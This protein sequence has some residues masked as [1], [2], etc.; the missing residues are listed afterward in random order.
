MNLNI[1]YN[2]LKEYLATKKSATEFAKEISLGG[3]SVDHIIEQKSNFEK[4]VV[5]EILELKKHP[6]ADKLSLCRVNI[7]EEI[8]DIVCGAPNIKA[9]QKVPA[10]L[11]G[12]RVGEMKINKTKI[13]GAESSG[14]LC[15]QKELGL[16][17]D[18]AGI[19]ILPDYVKTGL[20]LEKVMPIAD[21][22][23]DIEI[24]SNRPDTM[25]V[26]GI[27]R[28]AAAIFG[29]KLKYAEPKPNLKIK[30]EIKLSVAVKELK[31]CPRYQAIVMNNAKVG[32]SPLWMQQRLLAAGLRPIN[33]LADITNYV[34]LEFGQ[35]MHVFDYDKLKGAEI[36]VRL[37]KKGEHILALDGK[38]YELTKNNLVIADAQNPVA[39]AGVMGGELSAAKTETKTIVFEAA[40]FD[41]I[42][43]RQTSRLLN[44]HSESSDLFE[45]GLSAEGTTPA[46][47]RA[48]ELAM[49]LAGAEPAS[50]VLDQ[51]KTAYKTKLISL[52]KEN[53]RRILGVKIPQEKIKEIL[54]R[55]GFEAVGLGKIKVKV[56]YWRARDVSEEHDLI[57]EIARVYGYHNLPAK[58][59]TGEIPVGHA[60]GLEFAWEDSVKDILAG[61]GFSE[62]Y[63]YS[64][65]SEKLIANCGLKIEN[66]IK[67]ANPLSA[68]FEYLRTALA[69]GILQAVSENAG[70]YKTIAIFELSKVYLAKENNLPAE[71][72]HLGIGVKGDS[73]ERVFA[74][75]KGALVSLMEKIHINDYSLAIMNEGAT[76][77]QKGKTV[78]IKLK[79][80]TIGYL[81]I[82]NQE[83]LRSFGIKGQAGLIELD[84]EKLVKEAKTSP[85]FEPIPVYPGIDLDLSMEID[86]NATYQAVVKTA[87]AVNGLIRAVAFLSV[88][89]GEKIPAGKKA[90]AIRVT[91]RDDS[92]TLTLAEAQ[93]IHQQVVG[94]LKRVYNVSVR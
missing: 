48:V 65:I 73:G 58:L 41:P 82:I 22:I 15:S 29:E 78:E 84:F 32:A 27:A 94:E 50:A 12:G 80:E 26:I 68:D 85:A 70:V 16:G 71:I 24:T 9:G 23:L 6:D 38:T 3:P 83:V 77:W 81:G 37:A 20:P 10:V 89:E 67:I 8:L 59:M 86:K 93:L 39:I 64:F 5:G 66:H 33:N 2:W 91:Y 21:N 45:K 46:L 88:Y 18:H 36:N 57:E 60:A 42:S 30:T 55:L 7:G 19:Y 13:R 76:Y 63:N 92:K 72:T 87:K 14:M 25:C 53:V 31:L 11:V 35:P 1:S 75:I 4:V 34:L 44:L 47:L 51:K 74:E 61:L 54:N 43:V 90:L 79:D 56:P 40:N 62:N 49:E 52:D 69:P 17:D 28:E